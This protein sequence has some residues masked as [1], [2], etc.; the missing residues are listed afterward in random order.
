MI[1]RSN[2]LIV[3]KGTAHALG[4]H[5]GNATFLC[6]P[7]CWHPEGPARGHIEAGFVVWFPLSLSKLVDGSQIP[8][9]Y[10]ALLLHCEGHQI[11]QLACLEPLL[12]TILSSSRSQCPHQKDERAKPGS[13]LTKLCSF[14]LPSLATFR[15]ICSSAILPCL[16]LHI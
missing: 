16:C 1:R 15:L 2:A 10:C 4:K 11:M 7:D 6:L 3:N 9:C 5:E 13:L 12:I 8:S 14:S